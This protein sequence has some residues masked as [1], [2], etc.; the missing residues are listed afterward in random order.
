MIY[1]HGSLDNR[2]NVPEPYHTY[3]NTSAQFMVLAASS[4]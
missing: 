2:F 1:G 3:T 4:H